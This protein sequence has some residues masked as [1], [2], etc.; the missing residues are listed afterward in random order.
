M[1]KIIIY[2]ED[3]VKQI[4]GLLNCVSVS[5]IQNSKQIAAVAQILDSGM[6]G[7][8]MELNK[9][10]D[11]KND[12]VPRKWETKPAGNVPVCKEKK[13]EGAG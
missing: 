2:T 6:P 12:Y 4:V 10:D 9:S 13:K 11:A 8:I 1:K 7:E 5:G 3:Q